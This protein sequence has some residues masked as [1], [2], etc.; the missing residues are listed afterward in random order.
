M[1][2][3]LYD[4]FNNKEIL[5]FCGPKHLYESTSF[6]LIKKLSLKAKKIIIVADEFTIMQIPSDLNNIHLIKY[7]WWRL[8]FLFSHLRIEDK[9]LLSSSNFDCIFTPLPIFPVLNAITFKA[10]NKNIPIYIY[11]Q[12][13]PNLSFSS[14]KKEFQL[15]N[16]M[17]VVQII[18]KLNLSFFQYNLLINK[19]V[20]IL[21]KVRIRFF[22]Y[23]NYKDLRKNNFSVI[24]KPLFNPFF[25][26]YNYVKIKKYKKN[27]L[28]SSKVISWNKEDSSFYK[29]I[30]FKNLIVINH[31]AKDYIKVR[32]KKS[33]SVLGVYPTDLSIEDF[34][35]FNLNI[36]KLYLSAIKKIV[37]KHNISK[38]RVKL[39]PNKT[40]SDF[41]NFIN[42]E[43]S[44]LK[45][46]D[47]MIENV[48]SQLGIIESLQSDD[49]VLGDFS[50]CLWLASN[51]FSQEIYVLDHLHLEQVDEMLKYSSIKKVSEI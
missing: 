5:L 29:L 17:R 14:F 39:H 3:F 2:N 37:Y 16:K 44:K 28:N 15:R 41:L 35:K 20:D 19:V 27:I 50:S 18:N 21:C 9:K 43:I 10:L 25:G 49:I 23:L 13:K 40:N 7:A 38:I 31:P 34:K 42:L 36:I 11:D 51:I 33:G 12:G 46:K 47:L 1:S 8:S 22:E 4:N 45:I 6:F 24:P 30:G 32:E 48:N 26:N